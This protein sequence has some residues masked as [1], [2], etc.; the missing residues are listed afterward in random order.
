MIKIQQKFFLITAI[1]QFF[2]HSRS[3][4]L[5]KQ[6]TIFAKSFEDLERR[7]FL[8]LIIPQIGEQMSGPE[9]S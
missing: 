2:S 3:E 6:N 5:L 1:E 9:I 7:K 8:N 4:Q